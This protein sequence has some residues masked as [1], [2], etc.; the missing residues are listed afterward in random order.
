M[1]AVSERNPQTNS[2]ISYHTIMNKW[3]CGNRPNR[4]NE[5]GLIKP[6]CLPKASIDAAVFKALLRKNERSKS[7]G[8]KPQAFWHNHHLRRG[9]T[10]S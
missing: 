4:V 3:V 2:R 1:D 6:V 7:G 10:A 9:C 5:T 8:V